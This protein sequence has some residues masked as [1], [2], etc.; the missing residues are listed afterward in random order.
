MSTYRF[1]MAAGAPFL[2]GVTWLSAHRCRCRARLA[3]ARRA[4][5]LEKERRERSSA[6]Y[7]RRRAMLWRQISQMGVTRLNDNE[8]YRL[9]QSRPR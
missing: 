4:R 2:V 1:L 7:E 9:S 3:K 8:V 6:E 5:E